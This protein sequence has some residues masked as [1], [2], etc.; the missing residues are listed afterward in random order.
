M[1]TN[2]RINSQM[3]AGIRMAKLKRMEG[4]GGSSVPKVYHTVDND[5]RPDTAFTTERAKK[6][7][8][9]NACSGKIFV[10]IP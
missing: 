7:G 1:A 6:T 8:K 2:P 10:T 5:E 4:D 3:A 9:A